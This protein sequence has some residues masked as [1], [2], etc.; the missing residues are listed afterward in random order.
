VSFELDGESLDCKNLEVQ[1]D[2][3]RDREIVLTYRPAG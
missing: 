1:T 3:S 2:I